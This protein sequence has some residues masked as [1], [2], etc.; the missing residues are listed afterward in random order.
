MYKK[1]NRTYP[2]V[3]IRWPVII[4]NSQT[5]LLGE[6]ENDSPDGAFI[7]CKDVPPVDGNFF[8]VIEAPD[9]KTM[10][11]AARVTWSTVLETRK[12]DSYFGVGVKFTSMS[13]NDR[14]FLYSVLSRAHELKTVRKPGRSR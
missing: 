8:M 7:S 14:K 6:I 13:A 4:Q 10:S 12:G 1:E 5:K 11:I 2:R 3:E 9:Y